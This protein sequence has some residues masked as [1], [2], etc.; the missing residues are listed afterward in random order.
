MADIFSK[1]ERSAIMSK[2]RSGNT[3]VELKA[4]QLLKGRG[5]RYQ[6]K[7]FGK[8]DFGSKKL[9]IAVFIDGCFWHK[10][11]KHF[12]MPVSNSRYWRLKIDRNL[13]RAKEVNKKLKEKGWKVVRVWEHKVNKS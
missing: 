13:K 3:K 10:C 8:P 11:P 6:P 5:L 12:R 1:K 9:K 2:V 7:I 4:K